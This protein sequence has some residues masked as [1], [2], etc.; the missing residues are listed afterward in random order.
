MTNADL[1]VGRLNAEYFQSPHTTDDLD[2]VAAVVRAFDSAE[3]TIH[4][5]IYSFTHTR[6]ADAMVRALARGVKVTGVADA[7]SSKASYSQI[8]RVWG[9]GADVRTWGS[10]GRLMH[11]KVFVIDAAS[12]KASAGL[13]SFNWSTAAERNNVEVL[14][15]LRGVQVSRG[16]APALVEQITT[17]HSHGSILS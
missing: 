9:A 4:F 1:P 5:A 7:V 14:L 10:S 17:A 13:G 3:E 2:P 15:V 6:I 16:L 12:K 11:D 8:H